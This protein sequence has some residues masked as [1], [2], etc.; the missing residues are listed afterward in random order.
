MSRIIIGLSGGV[1]SALAA[2]LLL[3]RGFDVRGVYL[4]FDDGSGSCPSKEDLAM[5]RRVAAHL[6]IPLRVQDV[7][8]QYEEQVLAPMRRGY[9]AGITPNPD[10]WCNR[11]VKFAQLAAIADAV[12][13]SAIATGHYARS[14]N[15]GRRCVTLLRAADCIKD[16]TYF[17]WEL[18]QAQ[19][20]RAVFPI[21]AYTK[22]QVRAMARARGLPNWDRRST[23]GVCFL[24]KKDFS[25]Y[26]AQTIAPEPTAV[27]TTAGERVGAVEMGQSFTIGQRIRLSGQPVPRYVVA[28]DMGART[29]TVTAAPDDPARDATQLIATGTSWFGHAPAFGSCEARIRH[30]Q[31]PQPCT[32]TAAGARLL[33][34]FDA[35][36]RGIAPGQAIVFSRADC[37]LG[38]ANIAHAV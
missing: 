32:I 9:A 21:G 31:D 11:S 36:Q 20:A 10:T 27:V 30:R 18:T 23:R 38:G 28:R 7:S 1:D 2:A 22:E 24:G 34:R 16:Q 5:A 4:K 33:V 3:E 13:A 15:D 25:A 19:L 35:P 29:I 37:V 8:A 17:L 14:R 26:L 12:G 6:D